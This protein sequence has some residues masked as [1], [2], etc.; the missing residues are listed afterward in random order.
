MMLFIHFFFDSNTFIIRSTNKPSLSESQIK[1]FYIDN[2]TCDISSTIR[3][4]KIFDESHFR[5]LVAI[6]SSFYFLISWDHEKS[7]IGADRKITG[8][9]KLRKLNLA[10]FERDEMGDSTTNK[11]QILA[12]LLREFLEFPSSCITSMTLIKY[13]SRFHRKYAGT[14]ARPLLAL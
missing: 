1:S 9:L 14:A 6:Y 11:Q 2:K 13:W 5:V 7:A 12:A 3:R 10:D 4:M 8:D